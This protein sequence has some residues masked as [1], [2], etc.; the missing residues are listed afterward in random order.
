MVAVIAILGI[1]AGIVIGL[2]LSNHPEEVPIAA[3]TAFA[4]GIVAAAP[5]LTGL[6]GYLLWIAVLALIGSGILIGAFA[7]LRSPEAV[8]ESLVVWS[9]SLC[10]LGAALACLPHFPHRQRQEPVASTPR[11]AETLDISHL[12]PVTGFALGAKG[13]AGSH[14][15]AGFAKQLRDHNTKPSDI[16]LLVG[17]ADCTRVKPNVRET[18]DTIAQ[19]RAHWVATNLGPSE[20]LPS[21][22]LPQLQE[23]GLPQHS[24]CASASDL[25][26]VQ[27]LLIQRKPAQTQPAP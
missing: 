7:A 3:V 8:K 21:A 17:S 24:A 1:A 4:G 27:A 22:A 16:L 14:P 6:S 25:R 15:L 9:V 2:V 18:N 23:Q 12:D 19:G 26:A 13:L 20:G 5:H 11:G 10:V